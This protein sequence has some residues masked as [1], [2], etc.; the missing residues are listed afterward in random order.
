MR[1][2]VGSGA[3][4]DDDPRAGKGP[5]GPAELRWIPV[6]GPQGRGSRCPGFPTH[7]ASP[8]TASK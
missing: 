6:T 1:F 2:G 8:R 7:V 5:E 4:K 3:E